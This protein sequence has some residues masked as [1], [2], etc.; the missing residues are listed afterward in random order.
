[1][2]VCVCVCKCLCVCVCA[3]ARVCVCVCVRVCGSIPL[4]INWFASVSTCADILLQQNIVLLGIKNA[5][6]TP[7]PSPYH[8][9]KEKTKPVILIYRSFWTRTVVKYR[10]SIVVFFS[11]MSVVFC[12]HLQTR[13]SRILIYSSTIIVALTPWKSTATSYT[14]YPYHRVC[15][16]SFDRLVFQHTQSLN[17]NNNKN[18]TFCSVGRWCITCQLTCHFVPTQSPACCRPTPS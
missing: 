10:A 9:N 7:S 5:D 17:N 13:N 1:V 2:C 4:L 11:I 8:K 15:S 6:P 14:Q 18:S 3:R 16:H 12:H